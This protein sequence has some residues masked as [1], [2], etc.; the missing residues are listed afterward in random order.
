VKNIINRRIREV[1]C[2]RIPLTVIGKEMELEKEFNERFGQVSRK[3]FGMFRD[4][5][6]VFRSICSL[7]SKDGDLETALPSICGGSEVIELRET[8]R[9]RLL[10]VMELLERDGSKLDETTMKLLIVENHNIISELRSESFPRLLD[11]L[12]SMKKNVE[13][14]VR[15]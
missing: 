6:R 11:L 13:D 9:Q 4:L 10:K 1:A 14:E 8:I 15:S 5:L 2:A 7:F 12:R 3:T